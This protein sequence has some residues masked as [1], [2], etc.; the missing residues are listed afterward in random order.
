MVNQNEH[1]LERLTAD[2]ARQ[3]DEAE[4]YKVIASLTKRQQD[5]F[6]KTLLRNQRGSY[7]AGFLVG[8]ASSV[9]VGILFLVVDLLWLRPR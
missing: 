9:V 4:R 1:E 7:I 6:L 5:A 3:K 8:V 2:A